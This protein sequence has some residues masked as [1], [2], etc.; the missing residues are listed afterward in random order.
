M[1]PQTLRFNLFEEDAADSDNLIYDG[2]S[3]LYDFKEGDF[4]YENGNPVLVEGKEALKVWIEKAI[5]TRIN[6]Y[7][8]YTNTDEDGFSKGRGYG[9][10]IWQLAKGSKLP[11][12][13]IQAETKRDI[14]EILSENHKIRRVENYQLEQGID[15]QS[16]KLQIKFD[17]ITVDG[18]EDFPMEVNF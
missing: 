14:E 18:E 4:I 6:T 12:L 16:H 11:I 3:F 5:R 17:V 8:I 9:S 13:I 2:T 15:G 7:E 1:I 10:N